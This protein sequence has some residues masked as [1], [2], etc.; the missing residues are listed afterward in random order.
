MREPSQLPIVLHLP[1]APLSDAYIHNT[2]SFYLEPDRCKPAANCRVFL[3][4]SSYAAKK[5]R[6]DRLTRPS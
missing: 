2:L 6:V 5:C 1:Q 4:L 3:L